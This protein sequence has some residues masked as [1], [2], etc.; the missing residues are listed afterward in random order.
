M[1]VP[2]HKHSDVPEKEP[3][4]LWIGGG[5]VE[6]AKLRAAH[7][8]LMRSY[9]DVLGQAARLTRKELPRSRRDWIVGRV[10]FVAAVTRRFIRYHVRR[11]SGALIAI[12]GQLHAALPADVEP[13][14]A[15]RWLRDASKDLT[16]CHGAIPRFRVSW[17]SPALVITVLTFLLKWIKHE[18][19]VAFI[20]FM[21]VIVV[22]V[23][24]L[25]QSAF[26]LKRETFLKPYGKI[27]DRTDHQKDLTGVYRL[28]DELFGLV[29]RRAPRELPWDVLLP[30]LLAVVFVVC[31]LVAGA[32]VIYKKEA[33]PFTLKECLELSVVV[34]VGCTVSAFRWWRRRKPKVQ[35]TTS[36]L[37]VE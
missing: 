23:L 8:A 25:V 9:V 3:A 26:E 1:A 5:S 14:E 29:D 36:S 15:A 31:Y 35:A 30:M 24:L 11:V 33:V 12:Y 32:I 17:A 34:I 7:T 22:P 20:L 2:L 10:P 6:V 16:I 21:I 18:L 37:S 4:R 28:E 27:E 13:C 19:A